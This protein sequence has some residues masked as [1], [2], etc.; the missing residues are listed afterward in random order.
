M[1]T[2]RARTRVRERPFGYRDTARRLLLPLV[3][4][5]TCQIADLVTFGVAV[6]V[7][8]PGPEAGPFR[9]V[10]Q[11]GGLAGVAFLKIAGATLSALVLVLHPWQRLSVPRTIALVSATVGLLG[12]WTNVL[13]VQ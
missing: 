11:D 7:H 9:Y 3:L 2:L 8:G 5:L 13:A 1:T 4:L 6:G 12:A 10:Y